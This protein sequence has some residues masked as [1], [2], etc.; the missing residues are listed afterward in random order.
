MDSVLGDRGEE[1]GTFG[2]VPAGAGMETATVEAGVEVEVPTTTTPMNTRLALSLHQ[3]SKMSWD[4]TS[5]IWLNKKRV[6]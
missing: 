5:R 3:K 2:S 4:L 6:K 1:L